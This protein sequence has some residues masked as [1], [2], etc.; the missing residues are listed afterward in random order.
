MKRKFHRQAVLGSMAK[1]KKYLA[2]QFLQAKQATKAKRIKQF[3][4]V[5]KG[6]SCEF[7]SFGF[8]DFENFY[9][10]KINQLL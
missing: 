7:K 3:E 6:G 4:K 5:Y 2:I 10:N 8:V 1:Q 9:E